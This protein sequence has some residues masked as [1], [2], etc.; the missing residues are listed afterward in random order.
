MA[1]LLVELLLGLARL[2]LGLSGHLLRLVAFDGA[3]DVVELAGDLVLG[4]FSVALG[5]GGLDFGLALSVLLLTGLL[6]VD[7]AGDVADGLLDGTG[8][9]VVV[10]GRDNSQGD[11]AL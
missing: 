10:S 3:D 11:E 2:L 1:N 4:T 6:P 8:D 9:R 5:L 7:G